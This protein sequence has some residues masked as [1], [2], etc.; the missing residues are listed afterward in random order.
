MS[1]VAIR[2][3]GLGKRYRLGERAPYKTIRE[4]ITRAAA[5][6]F[7]ALRSRSG[8]KIPPQNSQYIWAL[9]DVSLE[10]KRGEALGIIGRNGS[11]KST[12]LKILARI[13][14]P[15]IGRAQI[16]G[17]VGSLLEV[18]T[19][20]HPEL[21]GRE[22]IY[23]NGAILGMSKAEIVRRFDEIVAF[24]GIG[25]FLDTPVKHYSSGMYVRLAF[26]IAAHVVPDILLLDEV[27]AVGDHAFREKCYTRLRE[28]KADGRTVLLVSHDLASVENLC[29]RAVWFEGGSI[30]LEGN[31]PE[32]VR[33]YVAASAP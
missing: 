20:F 27:L 24:S 12:L 17:Q 29:S 3:E 30:Q 23:L 18:G 9:K 26:A 21:T 22:N 2:I 11:G 16:H 14:E 4:T 7:R 6:P 10:V 19:G 25:K 1:D 33:R 31:P 13:T 5:A 15:T 8:A 32:V 28:T